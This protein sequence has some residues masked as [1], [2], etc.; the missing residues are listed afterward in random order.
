MAREEREATEK[1]KGK[2]PRVT[3]LRKNSPAKALIGGNR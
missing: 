1:S 2:R 3:L